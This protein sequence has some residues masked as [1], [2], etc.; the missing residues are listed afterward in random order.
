MYFCVC[1]SVSLCLSICIAMPSTMQLGCTS[2]YHS[3][4]YSYYYCYSYCCVSLNTGQAMLHMTTSRR[5]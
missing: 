3:L 1:V 5:D 2:C 4:P